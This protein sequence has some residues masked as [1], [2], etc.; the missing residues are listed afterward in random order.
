MLLHSDQFDRE[1]AGLRIEIENLK[2]V[3]SLFLRTSQRGIIGGID[4]LE[5]QRAQKVG[6]VGKLLDRHHRD[7]QRIKSQGRRDIKF[8][9]NFSE[10]LFWK[11]SLL[12][13]DIAVLRCYTR[14]GKMHEN[15][16]RPW[17]LKGGRACRVKEVG[18]RPALSRPCSCPALFSPHLRCSI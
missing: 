8:P 18:R 12:S 15:F 11:G 10:I 17:G 4:S 3:D 7:R 6:K 14:F 1:A 9:A 13:L 2:A 5:T 16:G